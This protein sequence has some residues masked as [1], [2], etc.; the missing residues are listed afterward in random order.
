MYD[1]R[2]IEPKWLEKWEEEQLFQH[3]ENGLS[4]SS[5]LNSS[6]QDSQPISRLNN[7][8]ADLEK[9]YLLFAFAY[10]SGSGLHVG[11]VESKTAL[12]ILARYYRMNNK[13][14]FFPVGWD[15]FGLPAENYAI[16]TGVPPAVT[17]KNAI[18][19][20]RRQIK[21][22]GIS[23]DWA[24]EIA[25]NHPGYYKWTQWL[26]IQL[27]KKGLAYQGTGMVN[28]C[29]SCQTVLANEQVVNGEC[30]R[31]ATSVIQKEMKQWFF[32]I[33]Q[34]QDELISGLDEVDW[35]T[36]TKQQQLHWIG[37]SEG[38]E[39]DFA[40]KDLSTKLTCFTTRIDTVYGVTFIAISPE[41]FKELQLLKEIPAQDL[42]AVENYLLAAEK[43]TEEQRKIGEKD[44][45]GVN[46]GLHA[47]NPVNG[48]EVPIFVADYVLGGYGTGA[49]MGV[50][51]HD[52]RDWAFAVK[53][54]IPIKRVIAK[55]GVPAR[56]YLM[57]CSRISDEDLEKIGVK[58]VE[59]TADGDRKIEIPETKESWKAYEELLIEKM[60]SGYWNEQIGVE[61]GFIWKS[62]EGCSEVSGL[63]EGTENW[64]IE[65]TN[66]LL[67]SIHSEL[68]ITGNL[69]EF[70]AKNAWYRE[71][72]RFTGLGILI[73][74]GEFSQL[75]SEEAMEKIPAT[76]PEV[77]RKVTTY[78]L[79]DWLISRQRYWGAPIPIIYDPEGNPHAVEDEALPW[80]LPTDVD[81]KPTGESPLVSSLE[82]QQRTQEYAVKHFSDLIKEKGWS[83]DGWGWRPEYD[84]MDTF[85]DSSWYYLR[86]V[87]AR[88]ESVFADVKQL[89]RWLPV[90]FYMIGPEHIVLHLLYSRFFTKFLR[91][92]G[93][94]KFSEPFLKMRH[95]GMIL[96]PD[97]RKMSKSKGNVINPD[98]VI[99]LYGADT[100]RI[101]E[102]FMGPIEA[103]KPWNTTAVAGVYRFLQR[104][105]T[106]FLDQ[107]QDLKNNNSDILSDKNNSS[108]QLYEKAKVNTSTNLSLEDQKSAKS[109]SNH[110]V[111]RK[112]HQTIQKVTHDIPA[113]KYNTA[114]A[115]LMEF[116]NTWEA[117][118]RQTKSDL[119][120][121]QLLPMQDLASVAQLLA[122]F[123]PFLAEELWAE[124]QKTINSQLDNRSNLL[125]VHLV[126]WPK[127]DKELAKP[128]LV[129]IPVQINGKLRAV[130]K[131]PSEA[132]NNHQGVIDQALALPD[133]QKHLEGKQV[134][135]TLY[136]A[137]RIVNLVV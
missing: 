113:L 124:Y 54:H 37:K 41:K 129:S 74:S 38:V 58:I 99:E 94:L 120:K 35:P 87:S 96:G 13:A 102:M 91:D 23:Y 114:I 60:E 66:E 8:T 110:K 49:V 123:A 101:Y 31:C 104:I 103:D 89:E 61:S 28:W 97:G 128:E 117:E 112:L 131:L 32:K 47:I 80:L 9:I 42:Q 127:Y 44:K 48:A 133:I 83:A 125:S 3:S 116:I 22:I 45:T 81:F 53:H 59:K 50:P 84:T 15:A 56:S 14:V 27:W 126:G 90:D 52:E 63:Q 18:D 93:Y 4:S 77:M 92:E 85:V 106:L 76:F 70:L 118:R 5:S 107:L 82:F 130:I 17:T 67:D 33:T 71:Y 88:N 109:P 100:L 121:A 30:E 20:F 75:T 137:G 135:K 34:Y 39:I 64:V 55:P 2:I 40:V 25:T 105:H 134:K 69:W 11:H 65:R 79:R 68:R 12:D 122:P 26:F 78:K 95:Q 43:K 51:C 36:P 16:K 132:L 7:P 1:H 46:T 119:D 24:N 72:I 111:L 29:D 19:T 73:N 21:R 6:N 98:E 115:G 62:K 86:Y 108:A 57:G 136:I 10:P